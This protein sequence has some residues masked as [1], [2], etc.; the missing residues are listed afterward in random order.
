MRKY[1]HHMSG[2][3]RSFL[4]NTYFDYNHG[5]NYI[6]W[7]KKKVTCKLCLKKMRKP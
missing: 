6:V 5:M 4:C 1:K 7:D 3:P 2:K